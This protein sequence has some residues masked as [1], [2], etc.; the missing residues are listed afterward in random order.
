MKILLTVIMCSSVANTC[1]DPY[2]FPNGYVDEYECML[3]GYIKSHDKILEIGA[4]YTTPFLLE[5]L[6]NNERVLN[7]SN[8]KEEYLSNYSYDPKLVV[9]DDNTRT[10]Y[11]KSNTKNL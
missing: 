11:N 7:D 3:D 9:V 6:V 4:G 5:A 2:T 8:V 1:L 10:K